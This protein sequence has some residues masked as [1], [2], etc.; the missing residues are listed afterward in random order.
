MSVAKSQTVMLHGHSIT[1]VQKG[2]GPV[3]LLIHGVAGSLETWRSV[4]DPLARDATVLAVDLPDTVR[5]ARTAGTTR[6]DR[7]PPACA[8]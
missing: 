6:S 3:L 7:W 5:P 2:T 4:I 1:Y 8:T